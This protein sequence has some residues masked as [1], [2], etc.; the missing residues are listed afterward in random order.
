[1]HAS[2][3]RMCLDAIYGTHEETINCAG[4]DHSWAKMYSYTPDTAPLLPKGTILRVTGYFDNTSANKNVTD[5]RNWSGL[6]FR[7]IDNMLIMI[8]QGVHLTDA[9]YKEEVAQRRSKLRLTDGQTTPGCP[10]CSF[11]TLPAATPSQAGG[12]QP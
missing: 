7:S 11:A 6:G 1:M 3:V 9:Q 2:G 10:A 12:G 5:P 4:Y 8:G